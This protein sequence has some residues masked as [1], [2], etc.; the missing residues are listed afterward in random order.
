MKNGFIALSAS[1]LLGASVNVSAAVIA[2]DSVSATGTYTNDLSL[3]TDGAF[4]SEGSTWNGDNTVSFNQWGV[5]YDREYFTF[6][7][8]SLFTID[9]L[10]ISVDNNDSYTIEH[11]VDNSTWSNLTN[12]ER[13]FGP[14]RNGMDTFSSILGDAQYESGID[15]A[16]SGAA[17]YLRIYVAGWCNVPNGVCSDPVVGDGAYSIGEFQ[18]F[19]T[20]SSV[21]IPAA[22]WL[23]GS[24]LLGLGAV[25]R[26][27][28]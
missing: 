6:D 9:D 17:Q 7:M 15:F 20:P 3:L 1:L 19:G 5:G 2:F 23:F 18:V 12:V 4:P 16:Q 8:G 28:R 21:P 27:K 22:A 13:G 14:T 10:K 11:S 24:A 25:K 26:N